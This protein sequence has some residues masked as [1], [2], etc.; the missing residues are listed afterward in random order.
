[1]P[2]NNVPVFDQNDINQNKTVAILANIPI[3]FWLPLVSCKDSEF[4]KFYSNQ[5][6]LL[7]ILN[8]AVGIITP[9]LGQIPH[10]GL[11]LNLISSAI[12]IVVFVFMILEMIAA[13]KGEA[14]E[15]PIIGG[16]K[17]IK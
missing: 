10:M 17:I 13:S 16:I 4:G 6:L 11:I 15:M 1:M 9:I 7:L 2:E 12:G 14:K 5:G 3:L 8:V